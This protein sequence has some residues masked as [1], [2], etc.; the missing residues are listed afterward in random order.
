MQKTKILLVESDTDFLGE[1]QVDQAEDFLLFKATDSARAQSLFKKV[2]PDCCIIDLNLPH[3]LA[4]ADC[5]EGLTLATL[6][7]RLKK[8]PTNF[9]L[10][11]RNP[12]THLKQVIKANKIPSE[13]LEKH[14]TLNQLCD[15]R[16][17]EIRAFY[18]KEEALT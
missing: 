17:S 7:N 5:Y 10:I 2:Q 1:F 9:I 18:I 16:G 11:S 4:E 14:Q 6:L 12:L 3:F 15:S 13:W 8:K